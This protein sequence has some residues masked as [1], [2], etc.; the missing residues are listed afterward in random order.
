MKPKGAIP[1]AFWKCW[2]LDLCFELDWTQVHS[3][4]TKTP[5]LECPFFFKYNTWTDFF[6]ELL[7]LAPDIV[8][9]FNP[10]INVSA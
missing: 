6:Q 5:I 10:G 9:I 8:S 3:L 1:G 2:I 4:D 7:F